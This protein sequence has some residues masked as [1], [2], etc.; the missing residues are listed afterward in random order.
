MDVV[1]LRI[2]VGP[3]QTATGGS[4]IRFTIICPRI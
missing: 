2:N 1:D 4:L 3:F